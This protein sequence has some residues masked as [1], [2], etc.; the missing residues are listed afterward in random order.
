MGSGGTAKKKIYKIIHVLEAIATKNKRSQKS[1]S[2]AD[3]KIKAS[4]FGNNKNQFRKSFP[5]SW[6][7]SEELSTIFDAE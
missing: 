5:D 1:P 4:T 7:A 6:Q 2:S 3:E